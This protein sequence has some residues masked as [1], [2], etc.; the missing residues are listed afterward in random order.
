MIEWR[1]KNNKTIVT[2]LVLTM[3]DIAQ[4]LCCSDPQCIPP[5]PQ[6]PCNID[7]QLYPHHIYATMLSGYTK[8]I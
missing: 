6:K 3:K 2:I 4:P 1:Y 7:M 8:L 5:S